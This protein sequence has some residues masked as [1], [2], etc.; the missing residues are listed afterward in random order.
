MSAG[1]PELTTAAFPDYGALTISSK[2]WA[3]RLYTL[4]LPSLK[5]NTAHVTIHSER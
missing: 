3:G 4:G 5:G 2:D 1:L